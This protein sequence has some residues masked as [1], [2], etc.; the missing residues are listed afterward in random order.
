MPY[1]DLLS[2]SEVIVQELELQWRVKYY[3]DQEN[4]DIAQRLSTPASWLLEENARS[5]AS[6]LSLRIVTLTS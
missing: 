5:I 6:I 2:A 1:P 3:T 4:M